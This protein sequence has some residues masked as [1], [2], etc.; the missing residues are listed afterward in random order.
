MPRVRGHRIPCRRAT[1]RA[2]SKD[3]STTL[4]EMSWQG[5]AGSQSLMIRR[6]GNTTA[7]R[8]CGRHDDLLAV[9]RFRAKR[10]PVRV[11]KTRQDNDLELRF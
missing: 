4:Q 10:T 8:T 1:G 9:E 2:G 11:K 6:V 3:L 5:P 7:L